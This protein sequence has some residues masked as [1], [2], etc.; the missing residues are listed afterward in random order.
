MY[1]T[2]FAKSFSRYEQK[3]LGYAAFFGSLSITLGI[4][5]AFKAY[6]GPLSVCKSFIIVNF[7]LQ[8]S[9]TIDSYSNLQPIRY[10]H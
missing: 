7:Q 2:I 8:V 10:I 5:V 9:Y 6:F 3:K 1:E 4:C